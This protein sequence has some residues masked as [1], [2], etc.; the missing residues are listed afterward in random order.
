MNCR[1]CFKNDI[2][3]YCSK[4]HRE[5]FDGKKVDPVLA[6][7][8]PS[9]SDTDDFFENTKKISISGVQIKYSV[10]LEKKE[11]KLTEKGG[12]YILKPIPIGTFRNLDQA[13]ANE[14]L[15]MQIAKQVFKLS[16]P[17]NALIYFKDGS[18]AYLVRRFDQTVD[19]KL[20]QED[21]AQLAQRTSESHGQNYK[22]DITYEEIAEL[23]TQYLPSYRI[24]IEKFFRL[25][26]F[27]YVF[28]NG[29][30]HL[31][32]FSVIQSEHG[33]YILTPAY[34]LLCTR[35]H[36]PNEPDMALSLFKDGF[37]KAYEGTGFYTYPDFYEFGQRIG[38]KE[39]RVKKIINEFTVEK[40][41]I[42]TLISKSF[43][44]TELKEVYKQ[45]Y[46]D[47]KRRL[48]IG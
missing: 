27:N 5:L 20:Q 28:S 9:K 7:N 32:N 4:C 3:G 40:E 41:L 34:D 47:K 44:N 26:L 16:I 17:A 25:V 36:S 30:A 15:T 31:K 43:L 35:I 11:L 39:S 38:I 48:A 29:D 37:S 6:F 46:E 18:P 12:Q 2:D 22:Y 21:F 8:S 14:H 19:K 33:D 42:S 45:L 13:P 24:E 23:I 10:K 1:G